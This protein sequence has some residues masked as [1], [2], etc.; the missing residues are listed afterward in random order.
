ML[1]SNESWSF[2]DLARLEV[3]ERFVDAIE[4][5]QSPDNPLVGTV[6]T[7]HIRKRAFGR[8]GR[9]NAFDQFHGFPIYFERLVILAGGFRISPRMPKVPM[10]S[11]TEPVLLSAAS[12]SSIRL[13]LGGLFCFTRTEANVR[14]ETR[15]SSQVAALPR[16]D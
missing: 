5:D 6:V 12:A 13:C 10:R 3:I 8:G 14:A 2:L 9:S 7:L 4:L 15:D 16:Q 1:E 11:L